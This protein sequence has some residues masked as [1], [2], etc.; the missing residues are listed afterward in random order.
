[1]YQHF[2]RACRALTLTLLRGQ[3][4]TVYHRF[5]WRLHN[6]YWSQ[7]L[8]SLCLPPCMHHPCMELRLHMGLMF[9]SFHSRSIGN[10]SR[11][12]LDLS[13]SMGYNMKYSTRLGCFSI[14]R[15]K[16]ILGMECSNIIALKYSRHWLHLAMGTKLGRQA[17]CISAL[18]HLLVLTA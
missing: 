18:H 2:S 8:H 10:S 13:T 14:I 9:H 11:A 1:M 4:T 12:S 17:E 3:Y 7:A 6:Q 5:S 15:L 16:C